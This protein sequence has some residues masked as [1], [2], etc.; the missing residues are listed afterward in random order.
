MRIALERF[1][2][3]SHVDHHWSSYVATVRSFVEQDLHRSI[4]DI[5]RMDYASKSTGR[6]S[7]QLSFYI[8]FRDEIE[9]TKTINVAI[10]WRK[11]QA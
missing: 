7:V 9:A 2:A 11:K 4:E 5:E 3:P 1:F 10:A 6:W 8:L